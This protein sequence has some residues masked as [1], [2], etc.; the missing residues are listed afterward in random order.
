MISAGELVVRG[1]DDSTGHTGQGSLIT[2]EFRFPASVMADPERFESLLRDMAAHAT[3]T[4]SGSVPKKRRTPTDIEGFMSK[5]TTRFAIADKA[6]V[7]VLTATLAELCRLVDAKRNGV[8]YFYLRN[9]ARPA[10]LSADGNGVDRLVGNPPWMRSS[11][12]T[13][14]MQAW[15]R[16]MSQERGLW[17]GGKSAQG[18]DLSA[19]FVA[20]CCELYLRAGGAFGFVMPEAVLRATTY[21][22][23]RKGDW[24]Q[25]RNRQVVAQTTEKFDT[26][27]DMGTLVESFPFP[28]CVVFGHLTP[29]ARHR[30][31][32]RYCAPTGKR[33]S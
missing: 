11:V 31:A 4:A 21:Q 22:G 2:S 13:A 27:W 7:A 18:Q 20:R 19:L 30:W 29:G 26:P 33:A 10:W 15:F 17:T 6:D 23:F 16:T 1:D 12:M 24:S 14:E 9:E 8:W 28:S 25:R 3:T 5:I 32:S